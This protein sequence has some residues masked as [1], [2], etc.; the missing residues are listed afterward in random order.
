MSK[1]KSKAAGKGM[2]YFFVA[3]AVLF[4][5][6][7]GVKAVQF[8]N[9]PKSPEQTADETETQTETAATAAATTAATTAPIITTTVPGTQSTGD[10]VVYLT[11]D[12][13]PTE[14]T[15]NI[16]RV[17]EEN[18]VRGTFFVIHTY[19]GCEKQ[20]REM[21]ERGHCVALH[22]YSHKYSIYQ[23]V[24]TYFDDLNKI[25]DLVY[26]ATGVRSKLV[27]FPGGTSNTVSRKYKTGIM[28][29]LTKELANRGYE[30]FDWNVD[31][32]DASAVHVS[33]EKI[34][35]NSTAAIGELNQIILLMHD[36]VAKTT[37]VDALP[38]IIRAYRDAGYRFD[39]LSTESYVW[40]HPVNN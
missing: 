3:L 18:G 7:A 35:R 29:A 14:N 22:T 28:T 36:A 1:K 9:G 25:S 34:V 37:T 4:A 2:T 38:D 10:K 23:S 19:D 39:V 31:S 15:E 30:Y 12:D 11:F 6:L 24:E 5:F 16:M 40:H 20:I 17:L 26:N 33:A 13:G 21:H 32:S 8:F 27:R